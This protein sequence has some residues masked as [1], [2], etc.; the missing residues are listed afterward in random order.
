MYLDRQTICDIFRDMKEMNT[1]IT[2]DMKQYKKKNS[3]KGK[4]ISK[5][6][7]KGLKQYAET[8]RRLSSV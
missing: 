5:A 7:R 3:D 1:K 2:K 8:F 4:V 6:V